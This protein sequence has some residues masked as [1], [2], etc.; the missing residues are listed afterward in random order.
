MFLGAMNL[1][2]LGVLFFA[3]A[4][5]FQIITLPLEF[6]A[7]NRAKELL[8]KYGIINTRERKGVAVVLNSAAMTYVAAAVAS[9]VQL[10]YFAMRLG[11]LGGDD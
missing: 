3:C 4:V 10:L 5:V 7:S 6:D 1:A 2:K 11:L 9:L 8:Y